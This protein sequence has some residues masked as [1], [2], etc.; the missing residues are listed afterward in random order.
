MYKNMSQFIINGAKKLAGSIKTNSA[1]NAAVSI[2]SAT[3]MIPGKT[4]LIDVP[5]IEDVKRLIEILVSIGIK[6]EWKDGNSLEINN[7]GNINIET[8]D[9]E[10]FMRIRSGLLLLGSLSSVL[11]SFNL[12]K[13]SG[14]NLGKRTVNPYKL[15]F[16]HMGIHVEESEDNYS[17]SRQNSKET[18]FSMYE[19]GDTATESVIMAACLGTGVTKIHFASANYMTQDLCIFL[20][21]AG[22]K[23]EG[24]G[25]STLTITGVEELSA[26]EE[27]SI[28]PDPIE[29]M[30]FLS[31]AITTHSN[32]T[33][34]NCPIDF[35]RL[36]LEKLRV[37]G[38][39]FKISKSY[40]S[41]NSYF[42]LV[43]IEIIPSE[44]RALPDKIYARPFPGINIDHLPLFVPILTQ[45]KGATLVHDWVYEN[46]AIY[47]TELNNLGASVM[48]HD[49]HR[50][51]VT[52]PT[53]F[54][55]AEIMCPP[56]LRP[57]LN[58]L[59]CMLAAPG[60][61]ILRNAYSINRGYEN[62]V[63]RLKTIGADI[64]IS[65]EE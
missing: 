28:M 36:E 1:K 18:E 6:V 64:E 31:I 12:P 61:S 29:A 62:I 26:V 19:S 3:A 63:E 52:G 57:A 23:I 15:A 44:L 40:K 20:T 4:T 43:N 30:S 60:K 16:D 48:L 8:L 17:I 41:K 50:V 13:S 54:K 14:C 25:T 10:A 59:I 2:I 42:D 49:P 51:T 24:I 46:R 56:A 38:Q 39:E 5:V 32:I 45:A 55:A 11:E 37:M 65:E 34:T 58:L 53:E 27:Y 35:L 47:Y 33:V 9:K 7:N 21:T 22:A